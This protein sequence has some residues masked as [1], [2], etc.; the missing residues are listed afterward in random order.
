MHAALFDHVVLVYVIFIWGHNYFLMLSSFLG[1]FLFLRASSILRLS[2][3]FVGVFMHEVIM[4]FE[5]EQDGLLY[6]IWESD[7]IACSG[8]TFASFLSQPTSWNLFSSNHKNEDDLN[9]KTVSKWIRPAKE[10]DLKNEFDFKYEENVKN[11]D[12]LKTNR[13]S[14]M[15]MTW[16]W[17]RSKK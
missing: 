17:R 16:K 8:I 5:V 2:H 6:I 14:K 4:I 3:I 7:T 11:E 10:D 13:T 1:W 15:K 12:N 9:M